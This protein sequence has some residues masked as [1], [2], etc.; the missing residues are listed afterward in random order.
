MDDLDSKEEYSSAKNQPLVH[1]FP[2]D[3]SSN[4]FKTVYTIRIYISKIATRKTTPAQFAIKI[5]GSNGC[6]SALQLTKIRS[7]DTIDISKPLSYSTYGNDVGKIN[8]I[9]IQLDGKLAVFVD[10]INVQSG[11][12]D[13]YRFPVAASMGYGK[14]AVKGYDLIP[15]KKL[16]ELNPRKSV[17]DVK[18]HAFTE[19]PLVDTG[20]FINMYSND[21]K[22]TGMTYIG[23]LNPDDKMMEETITSKTFPIF[24]VE[25]IGI[26]DTIE[27]T[28][29]PLMKLLCTQ[30]DFI[31][32]IDKENKD[33]FRF[34]VKRWIGQLKADSKSS[35]TLERGIL[36]GYEYRAIVPMNYFERS[37]VLYIVTFV[38]ED[39]I[40]KRKP[41]K[42]NVKI[43]GR[44][45]STPAIALVESDSNVEP[46]KKENRDTFRFKA[47]DVGEVYG[48]TIECDFAFRTDAIF[49]DV[50]Q[51]I[52][53][54][55]NDHIIFP[56]RRW[57]GESHFDGRTKLLLRPKTRPGYAPKCK[58]PIDVLPERGDIRYIIKTK[59]NSNQIGSGN[60]IS[61]ALHGQDCSTD[62]MPLR[63]SLTNES[64]FLSG[65]SDIFD[66]IGRDIGLIQSL[67]IRYPEGITKSALEFV[68]VY[69][70][71]YKKLYRATITQESMTSNRTNYKVEEAPDAEAYIAYPAELDEVTGETTAEFTDRKATILSNKQSQGDMTIYRMSVCTGGYG[72]KLN[73]PKIY[74]V[75][76][77]KNSVSQPVWLKEPTDKEF[78]FNPNCTDE[79]IFACKGLQ[80]IKAVAIWYKPSNKK[81]SWYIRW[82]VVEDVIKQSRYLFPAQ[83]LLAGDKLICI[84]LEEGLGRF[85]SEIPSELINLAESDPI[86]AT[87][88][89]LIQLMDEI[90]DLQKFATS[91][92]EDA[93]FTHYTIIIETN[94][95][96]HSDITLTPSLKVFV[97]F[98]GDSLSS[99]DIEFKY[100]LLNAI[101]F[102]AGHADAFIHPY[103]TNVGKIKAIKLFH[104]GDESVNWNVTSVTVIDERLR[105]TFKFKINNW[106]DE[107]H[108]G[109]GGSNP[110][111][112][113]LQG[114]AEVT[115]ST[116]SGYTIFVKTSNKRQ[117]LGDEKPKF[118]IVMYGEDY[119]TT[120][121]IMS[122]AAFKEIPS[123][124]FKQNHV[125]AFHIPKVQ[126]I[127]RIAKAMIW[128]DS[129]FSLN[130]MCDWVDI[131]DNENNVM[132]KLYNNQ[133]CVTRLENGMYGCILEV[134]EDWTKITSRGKQIKNLPSQQAL[135]NKQK[136]WRKRFN[137]YVDKSHEEKPPGNVDDNQSVTESDNENSDLI[138]ENKMTPTDI[139]NNRDSKK[140]TSSKSNGE[141]RQNRK[142]EQSAGK[143]IK[144]ILKSKTR[145]HMKTKNDDSQDIVDKAKSK[146][147]SIRKKSKEQVTGGQIS[148]ATAH[149]DSKAVS[150]VVSPLDIPYFNDGSN[151]P[152]D[153]ESEIKDSLQSSEVIIQESINNDKAS[154]VKKSDTNG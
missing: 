100:S 48:F 49:I 10:W 16:N 95:E 153:F 86:L 11:L 94:N 134:D 39:V 132:Y 64:P 24:N 57:L 66:K 29:D 116:F 34:P 74:A 131:I 150:D 62:W 43:H 117:K 90:S 26:I 140:S 77:D 114:E 149:D 45:A 110:L 105:R 121:E 61:V 50:I 122:L 56:V 17:Y 20:L 6:T 78:P 76:A 87:E 138:D 32:I 83:A 73:I 67:E 5:F 144:R 2:S 135:K 28:A 68:E 7:A 130:W 54:S 9:Y 109:E 25:R 102:Q 104:T 124:I 93:N 19:L 123:Q 35:L 98:L 145:D 22:S 103:I 13:F 21:N 18:I 99:D 127:G 97:K 79:F 46:F 81:D 80:E 72:F 33:V 15:G 23:L 85:E 55:K 47:I 152:T 53:P 139:K 148:E 38:T 3:K 52:I 63:A 115:K 12:G 8:R 129:D 119:N 91:K 151:P 42:V 108:A 92:L 146:K 154:K 125:D 84:C 58:L 75:M 106:I 71:I 69:V 40:T 147:D 126:V 51:L 60:E 112:A 120:S 4:Y 89:N 88:T 136:D 14:N 142:R 101:P 137:E 141:S 111:E 37:A 113:N 27:L 82:V 30:I 65:K 41:V 70:P 143:D 96:E 107:N 36:P 31:D 128:H 44:K 118:A 59:V 1:S 133:Q